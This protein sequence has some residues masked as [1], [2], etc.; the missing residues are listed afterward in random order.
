MAI[1]ALI[2]SI[3]ALFGTVYSLWLQKKAQ[4]REDRKEERET[5]KSIKFRAYFRPLEILD[6]PVIIDFNSF[7]KPPTIKGI[8]I[9]LKINNIGY[10]NFFPESI[11]LVDKCEQKITNLN[12]SYGKSFEN[13]IAQDSKRYK[14]F[15]ELSNDVT[16]LNFE[17]FLYSL[18]IFDVS[19]TPF[20]IKK[21]EK[22]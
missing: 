21:I 8:E 19:N 5:K 1:S 6:G 9:D 3:I 18:R 11:E 17:N 20:L 12:F 10:V 14:L 13:I 7:E 16:E 15:V 2:I 22:L 4:N